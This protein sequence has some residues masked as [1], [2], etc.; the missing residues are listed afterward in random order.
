MMLLLIG[1]RGPLG[2]EMASQAKDVKFGG[3]GHKDKKTPIVFDTAPFD[4]N[5]A[6]LPPHY[7]GHDITEVYASLEPGGQ[8]LQKRG[9]R[10]A[11]RSA[12]RDRESGTTDVYAFRES[13]AP[14]PP[15]NQ[16]WYDEDHSSFRVRI[17]V[18]PCFDAQGNVVTGRLAFVVAGYPN[19]KGR[20]P[21]QEATRWL[22]WEVSVADSPSLQ[23]RI[24]AE[25]YGAFITLEGK[26]PLEET[27]LPRNI[28][29]LLV[30]APRKA[31]E[32]LSVGPGLSPTIEGSGFGHYYLISDLLELWVYDYATG[33]VFLKAKIM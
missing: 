9:K 17:R 4:L 14:G 2:R 27:P 29:V 31:V 18:E 25:T 19:K 3:D 7:N 16:F 33:R 11:R 26:V 1:C 13:V 24:Q 10:P 30:C 15:G 8:P 5:R 32:G 28:S 6:G 12:D 21:G 23:K 20:A 22:L